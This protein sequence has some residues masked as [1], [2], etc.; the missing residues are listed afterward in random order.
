[1]KALTYLDAEHLEHE[2]STYFMFRPYPEFIRFTVKLPPEHHLPKGSMIDVETTGLNPE[3]EDI[4]TMG[5]LQKDRAV[6]HQLTTPPYEPFK[7]YCH[8][9]AD[10]TPLPRY[11]YNTG[12]E[13]QFLNIKEGW[14]DLTQYRERHGYDWH[15]S[16]YDPYYRVHLDEC[17]FSVFKEPNMRGADIPHTWQEW[18]TT[19]KP[20]TLSRITLHC[21]ADLLRTRQL[22]DR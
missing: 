17:T 4:I 3:T 2:F 20:E 12:F 9:K 10:R 5:I 1:M 13:S 8:N 7:T 18:L 21:L 15:N 14:H 19:H 16:D 11:S 6:V 22:I